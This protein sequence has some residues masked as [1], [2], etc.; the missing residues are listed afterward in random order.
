MTNEEKLLNFQAVTMQSAR[1]KS[2]AIIKE[3]EDSLNKAFE[4]HV[5]EKEGRQ[6]FK[7]RQKAR[8]LQDVKIRSSLS[9]RSSCVKH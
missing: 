6:N 5:S 9:N 3:F 8:I 1:E 7:S 2:A 4:E